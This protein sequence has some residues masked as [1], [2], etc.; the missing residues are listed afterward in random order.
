VAQPPSHNERPLP[1]GEGGPSGGSPDPVGSA[2]EPAAHP[3]ARPTGKWTTLAI[4]GI[5]VFMSTLDASIVN[6][7]LPA[8]AHRFEV[9]LNGVVEWVVIAYLLAVAALL[10]T[11]GR[12]ADMAGHKAIW[13]AGLATFTVGSALCGAAPS[14]GALVGFRAFQ[15]L[16]GAFLMAI[17]PAMLTA[18]FPPQERGRALGLNAVIVALGISTGPTLGGVLTQTLTWRAIFYVNV[19]IGLVGVMATIRWLR[20][21]APTGRGRF[22]PLGAALLALG[23]GG[24]TLGLSFGEEWG[25][26]SAPL[27][28]SLA[29]GVVALTALVVVERAVLEPILDLALFRNRLFAA[30]NVSLVLSFLALFA[31]SFLM[32]FYLEELRRFSTLDAGLLLTPLPL[33]LAIIAPFSGSLADR[34]GTRWPATLGLALACAGLVLISTLGADTPLGWVI[35]TL[36][37]TG[38]GQGLFQSP[39]N[40]ALMG[41]APRQRQ[42][43]AAGMLATGRVVGQSVSVALA[44]AIFISLGGAAAGAQLAALTHASPADPGPAH[45]T[46]LQHTFAGAFHT[47]FLVSATIAAVGVVTS[48]VRGPEVV[49]RRS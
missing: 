40:S 18:A 30:A 45:I 7:S 19:P 29:V 2:A 32:P 15:G 47:A 26:T 21:R 4:V 37:L 9:P 36:V 8:I 10:L 39:N 43:V 23:L 22:D 25:W 49:A 6:I 16:G 27:I 17:S 1:D 44:G 33:T 35:G 5:G 38:I 46:A 28:T 41:A 12:L 14:L 3:E 34:I 24:V 13:I 42:G 31:V 48:L 20:R 11:I